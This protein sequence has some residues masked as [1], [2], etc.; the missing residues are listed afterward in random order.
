MSD[1][2]RKIE[3]LSRHHHHSSPGKDDDVSKHLANFDKL[4]ISALTK[5]AEISSLVT[6][7]T[8][9]PNSK[10]DLDAYTNYPQ[11]TDKHRRGSDSSVSSENLNEDKIGIDLRYT[12]K[13]KELES[14]LQENSEAVFKNLIERMISKR[15]ETMQRYWKKQT[16][17]CERKTLEL[18]ARKLRM[19]KELLENDNLT[20]LEKA[21]QDEK[22]SQIINKQTL[23][24]MNKIL[25]EQNKATARFAAITDSH[26]KV[27]ICYNEINSLL[28]S[29][30]H[31]KKVCEK[32]MVTLNTVIVNINSI[33]DLCKTG[34]ITDKEVKQAEVLATNIDNVRMKIL[35]DICEAKQNEAAELTKKK[36]EIDAKKKELEAQR[37]LEIKLRAEAETQQKLQQ[38][39]KPTSPMFYSDK[40][41][42]YYEELK[43]FLTQYER[44]YKDL[45]ENTNYKKFRFDCQKAVNTP[46]NAIS[47]VSGMHIKDKYEKLSRLLNGER[48][49]VLDI[50]VQATQH[51]QGL[52]YVTALLAKKI[53]RQ[54]DL[55]VS[56]NP[57]AA[58][59][60]ASVTAALWSQFPEFGKLLEAYFHRECPYL[61]PMFLPQKEGQTDKEFY[62]SRGYTYNDEGVVEKQ[63]KFLKRMSGIFRLRCAIW[64]AKTPRFLNTPNPHG[65]KYG[66]QWM[67]SF[68]NLKP[69][70]DISATLLHDFFTVCGSEFLKNYG[71]QFVKIIRLVSTA[72]L[73]ILENL[74]EGGPKTRL[75]V[76][77]Q[78]VLNT[79]HITPP[80]GLLEPN[81][82]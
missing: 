66:W 44:Q 47:S 65:L 73:K 9:G 45:V 52:A 10:I 18:K 70:P 54:G 27:C 25:E 75:E 32:Y 49:Q 36:A 80:S 74:D 19:L 33:L 60:L 69:E 46:V 1:T 30:R 35:E 31:A 5:A 61:V 41:Y 42:A 67:A 68:I 39:A 63:D 48:V 51:P 76:F 14:K 29:D 16:E 37:D 64:I 2:L 55:L 50:F 57:E 72:Y 43:N 77:L 28:Q 40:N 34:S 79:S 26:T 59:P 38:Q 11:D 62:L 3:N 22:A 17:E 8:I 7:V 23:E 20:V 58:F 56:S 81:T 21:R 78:N 6:E 13:M 53:V 71:K 82:W 24:S 4:R 12:L 15:A